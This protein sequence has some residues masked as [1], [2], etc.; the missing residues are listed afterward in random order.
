M[1]TGKGIDTG[2]SS[3]CNCINGIAK[4]LLTVQVF[5]YD[6]GDSTGVNNNDSDDINGDVDVNGRIGG[7]N[8]REYHQDQYPSLCQD[9]PGHCQ[10]G[11]WQED[12]SKSKQAK[13]RSGECQND[14]DPNQPG[15]AIDD[16]P[17]Y[18]DM[19]LKPA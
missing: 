11:L 1:T 7:G 19:P 13:S 12:S 18:I 15:F 9:Q 17:T 5:D 16:G 4:V 3:S 14:R 6:S 10:P 2:T 8:N